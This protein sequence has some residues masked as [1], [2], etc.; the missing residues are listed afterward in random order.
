MKTIRQTYHL[1]GP[2]DVVWAALVEPKQIAIWS[3]A[4]ARMSA[5]VGSRFSLWGGDIHGKNIAVTPKQKLVQEWFGGAWGSPS[6]VSF[7]LSS[8]KG[9]TKLRLVHTS[10]PTAEV[11]DF[12]DGWK[13]Y[14]L[15]PLQAHVERQRAVAAK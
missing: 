3:G 6:I 15:G 9:K 1:R 14:Y 4:P 2:A 7:T 8:E 5:K 10:V 11:N 13:L 12:A